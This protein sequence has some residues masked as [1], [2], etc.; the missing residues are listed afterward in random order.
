METLPESLIRTAASV[1]ALGGLVVDFAPL[2]DGELRS[3]SELVGSL[4][5]IGNRYAAMIAAET[6]HRSRPEL[7]RSGM[8]ATAGYLSA[9]QMVQA[10]QG[11]SHRDAMKLIEVGTLIARAEA[12]IE[13]STSAAQPSPSGRSAAQGSEEDSDAPLWQFPLVAALNSGAL[14]IDGADSVRRALG[15]VDAAV[16]LAQLTAAAEEL[17]AGAAGVTPEAL[18]RRA[19]QLR[20]RLDEQ[21]IARREKQ[22]DDLRSVRM[23]T[24][25]NGMHC[26]FWRLAPEDGLIVATAFDALMSPRRGGPRFV[27]PDA[28]QA[29]ED[30]RSDTRTREQIA[31]DGLV[32][33]IR[34]AVDADPTVMHGARRPAVRVI[35]TGAHL[36]ARTGHGRLEGHAD[37]VPMSTVERH[38]CDTGTI[39]LGFD[40]DG[41]CVNVGRTQRL[42]TERQRIGMAVRDGGCMAPG[43]DRPPSWCEAHHI[44]NWHRDHGN[45]DIADGTNCKCHPN[46]ACA[47]GYLPCAE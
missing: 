44:D 3:A 25:A 4:V 37:P 40:D 32:G 33:M 20:D 43:C 28:V 5:G 14:S 47:M 11:I 15:E 22:R 46:E 36:S 21:G 27:H 39:A 38:V 12:G 7:G 1:A 30:L 19:R 35:V 17:V 34:L 2:T 26:G 18:S 13:D 10:T 8:A 42:F 16:T 45:T 23:W 9:A 29:A 6:A 24:D 41:Q 31:A